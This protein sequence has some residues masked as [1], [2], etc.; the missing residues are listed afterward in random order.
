MLCDIIGEEDIYNAG[1]GTS[2]YFKHF[3]LSL[4]QLNLFISKHDWIEIIDMT[5][6]ILSSKSGVHPPTKLQLALALTVVKQKPPDT[7]IKG[8]ARIQFLHGRT[9]QSFTI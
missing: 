8:K 6:I 4:S 1:A 5:E 7:D 3:A 9:T 2:S